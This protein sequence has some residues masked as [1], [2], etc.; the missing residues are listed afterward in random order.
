MN[1]SITNM[2]VTNRW[3]WVTIRI[4]TEVGCLKFTEYSTLITKLNVTV[5][6]QYRLQWNKMNSGVLVRMLEK[7]DKGNFIIH[8]GFTTVFWPSVRFFR[9]DDRQ[10]NVSIP[11]R[12]CS[13]SGETKLSQ[14]QCSHVKSRR[15]HPPTSRRS[16]EDPLLDRQRYRS[17]F[18]YKSD[19]KLYIFRHHWC[20]RL[21]ENIRYAGNAKVEGLRQ[22]WMCCRKV[23]PYAT[24]ECN[25]QRDVCDRQ[26][27]CWSECSLPLWAFVW[28]EER[29]EET[30][31]ERWLYHCRLYHRR[32]LTRNSRGTIC[33][34]VVS[35]WIVATCSAWRGPCYIF[36]SS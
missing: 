13:W 4:Q 9:L 35:K 32:S 7:L 28:Y 34:C 31:Y 26:L 15:D 36:E 21:H 19:H 5:P 30:T 23:R 27:W 24:K 16:A 8:S 25:G 3:T 20:I 22:A 33:T 6:R 11:L 1:L 10:A 18:S 12:R 2:N 14:Y 29:R 17:S